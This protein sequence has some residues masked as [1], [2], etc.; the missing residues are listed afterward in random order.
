MQLPERSATSLPT[1]W[2]YHELWRLLTG[3]NRRARWASIRRSTDAIFTPDDPLPFFMVH[4]AQI[5][6]LL[7]ANLRARRG[8]ARIDLNIGKLVENG[9]D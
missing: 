2:I 1:H 4:H 9:G 3:T 5:P 7:L 8:W 6:S